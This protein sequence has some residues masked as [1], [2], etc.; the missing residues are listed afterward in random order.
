MSN[1]GT[2]NSLLHSK[3]RFVLLISEI[4]ISY[5]FIIIVYKFVSLIRYL[6]LLYKTMN[7]VGILTSLIKIKPFFFVKLYK[8]IVGMF[9]LAVL[10]KLINSYQTCQ[11]TRGYFNIIV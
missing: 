7:V 2:Q 3:L 8:I 6:L 4:G 9:S 11:F 5:E 1:I 10:I